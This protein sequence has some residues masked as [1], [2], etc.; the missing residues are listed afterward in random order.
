MPKYIERPINL[1]KHLFHCL[2]DLFQCVCYANWSEPNGLFLYHIAESMLKGHTC[3]KIFF[4]HIFPKRLFHDTLICIYMDEEEGGMT[5][6]SF[7]THIDNN[8]ENLL[9][10]VCRLLC[11]TLMLLLHGILFYLFASISIFNYFIHIYL[12]LKFQRKPRGTANWFN[13]IHKNL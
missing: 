4:S 6:S 2:Y 12:A 1:A 9:I 8:V 7:F 11:L 5:S 3:G 10:N 13:I